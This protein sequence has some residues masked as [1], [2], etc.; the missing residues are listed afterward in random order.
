MRRKHDVQVWDLTSESPR[1]VISSESEDDVLWNLSSESPQDVVS[2]ESRDD[3][4]WSRLVT[5]L[6]L[7][8]KLENTGK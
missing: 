8:I 3:T 1:D 7:R 5:A 6:R 4:I 2:S